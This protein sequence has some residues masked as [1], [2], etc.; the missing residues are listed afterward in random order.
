MKHFL[1]GVFL[2][3]CSGFV[4]AQW[5]SDADVE[6]YYVNGNDVTTQYQYGYVQM[7]LD[8]ETPLG[9]I[10]YLYRKGSR[11]PDETII[12]D[13]WESDDENGIEIYNS[14]TI[15]GRTISGNDIWAAVADE[16]FGYKPGYIAVGIYNGDEERAALYVTLKYVEPVY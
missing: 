10:I 1:A 4:Y 16:G 15:S 13:G 11:N 5:T 6:T 2:I 8:K 7:G 12:I 14:V 3:I 9:W